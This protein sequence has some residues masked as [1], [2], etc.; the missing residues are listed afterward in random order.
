MISKSFDIKRM[1]MVRINPGEDILDAIEKATKK[2]GVNNG[3]IV[4]GIGSSSTNH[5]HVVSDGN[6]PPAEIYCEAKAP[7]DIVS[8]NGLIID[9]K[10]HS[11]ITFA[12]DK[13]A[14][15]GHMEKGIT[16]LTFCIVCVLET[17]DI[18][19]KDWDSF[20]IL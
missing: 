19:Y 11:H 3:V 14:Y 10:V 17:N 5:Y 13:V 8:I 1:V 7:A 4:Q 16:A 18:S 9:G 15:G 2:E 20:N 6:L 12:N